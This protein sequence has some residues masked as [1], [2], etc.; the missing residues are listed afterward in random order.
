MIDGTAEVPGPCTDWPVVVVDEAALADAAVTTARANELHHAWVARTPVVVRMV[1]DPAALRE[2]QREAR[3]PW[4]LG[5]TFDGLTRISQTLNGRNESLAGLLKSAADLA[6][7]ATMFSG[8]SLPPLQVRVNGND[9]GFVQS[10]DAATIR[11]IVQ[12]VKSVS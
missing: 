11:S 6:Q 12:L 8:V 7:W 2:P 9:A 10:I 4:Q 3:P 5:P 1:C